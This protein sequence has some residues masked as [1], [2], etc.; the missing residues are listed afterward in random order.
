MRDAT[1]FEEGTVAK[2]GVAVRTDAGRAVVSVESYMSHVEALRPDAFVALAPEV[3]C[4]A[5]RKQTQK[6]HELSIQWLDACLQRLSRVPILALHHQAWAHRECVQDSGMRVLG[7]VG[8]GKHIDLRIKSAQETAKREVDGDLR[9]R[10]SF[11]IIPLSSCSLL[12]R[13][14]AGWIRPGRVVCGT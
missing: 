1:G 8:G 10:A 2:E 14:R 5:S 12:C 13:L 4:V 6:V 7:V 11:L 9:H 3:S